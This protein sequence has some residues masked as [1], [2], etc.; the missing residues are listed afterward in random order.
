MAGVLGGPESDQE[1]TEPATPKRRDEAHREGRVPRS[2]ELSAAVLLLSSAFALCYA[3]GTALARQ[4]H[5]FFAADLAWLTAEPLSA[6]GAQALVG[7]MAQHVALGLLPF[8]I[9]VVSMSLLVGTLQGRGVLT[10]EPLTPKLSRLD[11]IQGFGRIFSL[12]APFT[13]AKSIVKFAV[14]GLVTYVALRKAWPEL[15]SLSAVPPSYLPVVVR[16]L[17]LQ[18]ALSV[19]LAFLL[20][21][22]ADYA[23][24]AY[25]HEKSLRMTKQEVRQEHKES[26][27]DPLIKSRIRS[28]Q[29]ATSR[30]RM[31]RDVA[32][33]DV[34]IT[35]PTHIAVA[36]KYD[37]E[38]SSA[39]IVLAM[40]ERKLAQRIKALAAQSGVPMVENRP[41]AH[42]LLATAKVGRQIP[43][44]LY[45]AVAEVL[46]YVYRRRGMRA[47]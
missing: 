31:L 18:L 43:A 16:D 39:P 44:S 14:L 2:Q 24:E 7:T 27:G 12:Q 22:A 41:L 23:F 40:G 21:A 5:A 3:G 4:V 17:S 28:L 26:E 15:T 38:A 34:I 9:I 25:R 33:A 45:A 11:P 37:A 36:L 1:R 42:A 20:L 47:E 29:R 32:K 19:G 35:N 30:K 46:A 6:L 8:G 13:L 10:L